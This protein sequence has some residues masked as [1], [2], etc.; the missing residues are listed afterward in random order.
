MYGAIVNQF[1]ERDKLIKVLDEENEDYYDENNN[2]FTSS[3]SRLKKPLIFSLILS[4][5]VALTILLYTGY[6]FSKSPISIMKLPSVGSLEVS[7]SVLF[8]SVTVTNEYSTS[9]VNMFA[10]PFLK[11]SILMEPHRENVV[12]FTIPDSYSTC[13][14]TAE[15]SNCELFWDLE[16][17][18]GVSG[19][20]TGC[21]SGSQFTVTPLG[22][23]R[24]SLRVQRKCSES[25]VNE[26]LGTYDTWVKYV[27]RELQSLTDRDRTEFLDALRTLWDVSTVDGQKLYGPK[28]KSLYYF[29]TIHND[30]GANP[31]CDEFHTSNGFVNSHVFLG[32]YLEQSLQL[33]NPR[34]ALHY[35]EYIKAFS[36]PD[37]AKHLENQMDGGAWTEILSEKF[38]GTNDPYSGKIINGRWSETLV[39][40]MDA[41]F[42]AREGIN[43]DASF[44]PSE[45]ENVYKLTGVVHMSSP[46]GLLRSP[47]NYNPNNF[48]TRYNN[49]NRI[50]LEGI[51][52]HTLGHYVGST[53]TDYSDFLQTYTV[54][55]P[56]KS[57][58]VHCEDQIHG[59]THFAFGGSGGQR[60]AVIDEILKN[61]H[62]FTNDDLLAMAQSSEVFFKTYVPYNADSTRSDLKIN[63]L[64][65]SAN[66]WQ[67]DHLV[68]AGSPGEANGPS[69]TCNPYYL[70]NP[71]IF[72]DLVKNFFKQFI[73]SDVH[74]VD[75]L[76]SNSVDFATRKNIM[77]LICGRM[78][79]DGEMIGSGAALD[80]LFWVA[81]GAIERLFQRVI[82]EDVLTDNLYSI[83]NG[84]MDFCSG[85][86]VNGTKFWLDGFNFVDETV[87]AKSMTN[88]QLINA[89][90]PMSDE[91]RDLI[92]YVYDDS[93]WTFCEGSESWFLPAAADEEEVTSE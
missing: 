49:V 89:L 27:R 77:N 62:G 14:T 84:R 9:N 70:E 44:F 15:S 18:N 34:V 50:T 81:H 76:L 57:Y 26:V 21:D 87:D 90:N 37:Y 66:P 17:P 16:G 54:S 46:Y 68:M 60:C 2:I 69:C 25:G 47:W 74:F 67:D 72:Q 31:Y 75:Y 41:D 48:T 11:D 58:L 43:R 35:F 63:P 6:N 42:Y 5:F 33:V 32:S 7:E 71:I 56:M 22:V 93:E 19:S 12:T 23:G 1:S 53:C 45:Q 83:G 40:R 79:F 64:S 92:N 4:S 91:Y 88:G 82:F 8:P 30:A 55:Q 78:Q 59:Y 29:A 51:S 38:F 52:S 20:I 10:Y 28:Y 3:A 73:D 65:C 80:P 85:H 39:P 24:Y 86:S 61:T 13:S 36:S